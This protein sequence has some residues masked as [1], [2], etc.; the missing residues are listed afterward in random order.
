[1]RFLFRNTGILVVSIILAIA[2]LTSCVAKSGE[3]TRFV[4]SSSLSAPS[5]SVSLA[6]SNRFTF[7]IV[8]DL[9]LGRDTA[10][11]D[12]ILSAAKIEGDAF[13]ILLGDNVDRGELESFTLL[14]QS[15]QTAGLTGS[16]LPVIGNHD[17]FE[18]GWTHYKK[19]F[20]ASH[21]SVTL[22]NSRFI[23]LDTA[24]GTVGEEQSIWLEE[25][26]KRNRATNTFFLSHYLPVVPQQRTY[27]RLSNKVEAV[28][29]MKLA[30]NYRIKA[31]LGAH[32]HSYIN[33][34]VD[35]V[36]YVVAG[37]GGGRRM[38]PLKE[39]FFVQ[40]NVDTET[41]SYSLKRVE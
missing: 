37:G 34:A 27:L 31:W 19:T 11:F 3:S 28:R 6:N 1:M 29:L 18:D 12:R 25:E 38:E 7:A 9:H 40:V 15:I 8:G 21:Y 14:T 17:V 23:A 26:L 10:R 36:Q 2:Y 20:G 30:Q 4:E 35:G 41:I 13:L 22:G 5:L 24:D 33:E 32:Y 39:F 16:V